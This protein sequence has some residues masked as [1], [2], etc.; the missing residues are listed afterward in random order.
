METRAI[1]S[2]DV[3][4]VG[5]GTNNFGLRIDEPASL[6]V[7]G[8]CLDAGINLFDTA[9]VYGETKSEEFLGRALGKRRDEAVIATKFGMKLDEN[10]FGAKPEYV[11]RAAEDSLRRLGTDRID[12]YLL[13]RPDPSTPIA[14]T[15]DALNDLVIEG[16]VIE[17]GCSAFT[18]DELREADAAVRPGAARFVNLQSEYSLLQREVEADVLPGCVLA[19]RTFVPYFPLAGGLLTGKYRRS[20]PPPVGT[21]LASNERMRDRVLNER[22]FDILDE[23]SSYAEGR[24][25]TLLEAAMSWLLCQPAVVSVIAGAT[26]PEQVRANVDAGSWKMTE[27]EVAAIGRITS[28]ED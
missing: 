23:L 10:R 20:E 11:R 21:R 3:S 25:H 19:G 14:Q 26:S 27:D 8:A 12:L 2:L 18:V 9:D 13:H 28:K 6:A 1:G 22:N 17:I 7:V 16:K 15:L 5:V 4:V 24:G